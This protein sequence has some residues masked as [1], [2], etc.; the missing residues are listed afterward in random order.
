[1][2]NLEKIVPKLALDMKP[3]NRVQFLRFADLFH[4][5]P[6]KS[7]SNLIIRHFLLV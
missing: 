3:E 7:Y 1:M 5:V 4:F 6:E 2:S